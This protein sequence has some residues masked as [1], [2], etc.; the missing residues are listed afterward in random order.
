MNQASKL[1]RGAAAL[2]LALM[3]GACLPSAGSVTRQVV[4]PGLDETVDFFEDEDNQ[5]RIR[6]IMASPELKAATKEMLDSL[7][8]GALDSGTDEQRM[9]R[10]RDVSTAYIDAVTRAVAKGLDEQLGPAATHQAE[11][12]VQGVLASAL[13]PKTREGAARMVDTIT[14]RTVTALT[15]SAGQGLRDDLGPALAKVMKEDLGPAMQQVIAE[16]LAPAIKDAMG[17][18]VAPAVGLVTRELTKQAVLG[19]AD[20]LE[21]VEFQNKLDQFEEK[22]FTR[23]GATLNKGLRFGEIAAMVLVLLV[24]TLGLIVARAFI[25]RRKVEKERAHSER[26][27]LLVVQAMQG[28]QDKPEIEALL[29]QIHERETDLA[30]QG[31][32][33]DLAKR[34]RTYRA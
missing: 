17:D 1:L 22:T 21:T 13:S 29:R 12:F 24:L 32:L 30:D 26:M 14:R 2:G 23:L 8:G 28:A 18:G 27:L 33:D 4:G 31:F 7:I 15:Q 9:A 6:K 19:V 20:A 25:Q 10:V 16:N 34:V 11:Q 5:R 3:C